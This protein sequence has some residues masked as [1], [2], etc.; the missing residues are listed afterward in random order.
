MREPNSRLGYLLSLARVR[1]AV[2]I[3]IEWVEVV[4]IVTEGESKARACGERASCWTLTECCSSTTDPFQSVVAAPY[5]PRYE[6]S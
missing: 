4:T 3:Y 5:L 2:V 1:V 6:R